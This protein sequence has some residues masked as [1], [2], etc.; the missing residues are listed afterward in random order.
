MSGNI[1][2]WLTGKVGLD[3]VTGKTM[4]EKERKAK[5]ELEKTMGREREELK[6]SQSEEARKEAEIKAKALL[7]KRQGRASTLLTGGQGLGGWG[8]DRGPKATLLGE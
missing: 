3:L 6:R 7:R 1:G 8:D 4:R 2:D 5:R